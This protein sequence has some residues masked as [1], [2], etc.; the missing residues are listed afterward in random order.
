M[1]LALNL[2]FSLLLTSG[3][4]SQQ[5]IIKKELTG[6]IAGG[7]NCYLVYDSI[8]K[9]AALIDP[10]DIANTLLSEIEQNK[11]TLKYILITHCHPDHMYG[12]ISMDLKRKFPDTKICFTNEGYNDMFEIV[13]N[14]REVYPSY[15]VDM[16]TGSSEGMRIFDMDY[17]KI[18]KPDIFIQ[19]GQFFPL[20]STK[21]KAIKTPGHARGSVSFYAENYIFT[22]DELQR[23]KT[24]GTDIS[25][26]SSFDMQVKSIQKLYKLP[27]ETIVYPGHGQS[28]TIGYEKI[29]NPFLS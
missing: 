3:I 18:G 29:N 15:I 10:G 7:T 8:S 19:D 16:I 27:D 17:K 14:W 20:G 24:G 12:I 11:L 28:T 26:A 9:E 6:F 5:L 23:G 1:K 2:I 25:P 22:G 13:A 21:I 4:Y